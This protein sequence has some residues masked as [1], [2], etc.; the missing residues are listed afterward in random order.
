MDTVH[1]G[2]PS[3]PYDFCEIAGTYGRYWND[4]EGTRE[5]VEVPFTAIAKRFLAERGVARDLA[6]LARNREMWPIRRA[7][8]RGERVPTAAELVRIFGPRLEPLPRRD[9][10]PSAGKVGVWTD[11]RVIVASERA[12]DGRLLYVEIDG[13][14]IAGGNIAGLARF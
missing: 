8:Q 1:G 3:P 5:L 10:S 11:G 14:R 6:Y 9:A 13:V 12:P 4:E 2:M 7:A